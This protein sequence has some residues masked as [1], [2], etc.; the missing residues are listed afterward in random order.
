MTCVRLKIKNPNISALK[1]ILIVNSFFFFSLSGVFV[2]TCSHC[3]WWST[4][5]ATSEK[6]Y[7]QGYSGLAGFSQNSRK[8]IIIMENSLQHCISNQ[9][10]RHLD[11]FLGVLLN[12][13]NPQPFW[14]SASTIAHADNGV[15]GGQQQKLTPLTAQLLQVCPSQTRLIS[16]S[17]L[18][19]LSLPVPPLVF[20][21]S[22]F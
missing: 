8:E 13:I 11:L 14:D 16:L 15:A 9:F 21:S 20:Y 12:W 17:L 19:L 4:R 10:E 2:H 6:L 5:K 18:P 7:S 22:W 3:K 1:W